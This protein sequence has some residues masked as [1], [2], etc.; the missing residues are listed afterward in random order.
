MRDDSTDQ[1]D[2]PESASPPRR[3]RILDRRIERRALPTSFSSNLGRKR[4]SPSKAISS[5]SVRAMVCLFE[6]AS[7]APHHLG[8]SSARG[9]SGTARRVAEAD[10]QVNDRRSHDNNDAANKTA[11]WLPN[12]H[13]ELGQLGRSIITA[14]AFSHAPVDYA[15]EYSLTLLKHK[16]YFNNRPLVRCLDEYHE[17]EDEGNIM[18]KGGHCKRSV[19]E[20]KKSQSEGAYDRKANEFPR[21]RREASSPIQQLDDLMNEILALQ[22]LAEPNSPDSRKKRSSEEVKAFWGDVRAQLW[23]NED[24]IH[25]VRPESAWKWESQDTPEEE[26]QSHNRR[27]SASAAPLPGPSDP[28][29]ERIFPPCPSWLPPPVPMAARTRAPSSDYSR[30][31]QRHST[32]SSLEFFPDPAPDY[33]LWDQPS[34]LPSPALGTFVPR[35][36]NIFNIHADM[37]PDPELPVSGVVPADRHREPAPRSSVPATNL[38]HND[39]HS[40][41]PSGG[42]SSGTRPWI[43]PPTWRFPLFMRTPSSPLTPQLPTPPAPKPRR[44]HDRYRHHQ[45]HNSKIST[46][47]TTTTATTTTSGGSRSSRSSVSHNTRTRRTSTATRS[48]RAGSS[49]DLSRW[50]RPQYSA[51][52]TGRRLTTEEKLSEIDAF[53]SSP[54]KKTQGRE[55]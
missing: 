49:T 53:L 44:G 19:T 43:R 26:S 10:R 42:G 50:S 4:P 11:T 47:T 33:P 55:G 37:Y 14:P 18:K 9:A 46:S 45:Q 21:E 39:T 16:S 27:P 28:D 35:I 54:V 1:D 29:P 40:R 34:P 2:S 6:G 7:T 38:N 8:A 24:E 41:Y 20:N 5:R 17:E 48:T 36:P 31:S 51:A 22:G 12:S 23:I 52:V 3:E 32:A 25:A 13:R 15:E 30:E